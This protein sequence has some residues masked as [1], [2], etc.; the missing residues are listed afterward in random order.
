MTDPRPEPSEEPPD[1]SDPAPANDDDPATLDARF[2]AI[3]AGL[4]LDTHPGA[5]D[6]DGA[7]GEDPPPVSRPGSFEELRAWVDVHPDL[8][9]PEPAELEPE[10]AEH[11]VPPPPPPLPHGDRSTRWA[12]AGALGAPLLYVGL[13]LLGFDLGGPLGLALLGLF[14]AGFVALVIRMKDGPKDDSDDGAVV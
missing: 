14:A 1:D 6:R 3:V 2:D 8:L 11:F 13:S 9:A 7:P 4:E 10:D 5:R 12:W